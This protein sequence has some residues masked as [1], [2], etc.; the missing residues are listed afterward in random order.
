MSFELQE[1][2]KKYFFAQDAILV[3]CTLLIFLAAQNILQVVIAAIPAL[4]TAGEL[5]RISWFRPPSM[6]SA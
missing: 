4:T 6:C 5:K 1:Q 3:V 2:W